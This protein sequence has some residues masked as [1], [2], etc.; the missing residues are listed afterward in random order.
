MKNDRD[1]MCILIIPDS[2]VGTLLNPV[3]LW[4]WNQWNNLNTYCR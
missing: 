1:T 2:E 3:I 4:N